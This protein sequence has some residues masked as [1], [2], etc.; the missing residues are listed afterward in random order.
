MDQ[1]EVPKIVRHLVDEE[2]LACAVNQSVA[3]I[4]LSHALAFL[5]VEFLEYAGVSRNR[6]LGLPP[7]KILHE[8]RNIREFHRSLDQ[9]MRSEN[10][11][12]QRGTGARKPDDEN[13]R[14]TAAAE[15]PA[16]G[17]ELAGAQG[18]LLIRDPL[19]RFGPIQA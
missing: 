11:L 2:R 18:F 7:L 19:Q 9:R 3:E 16:R 10:L 8:P 15:S 6:T 17:E 5:R 1:R 12:D 4:A 13:R 14:R